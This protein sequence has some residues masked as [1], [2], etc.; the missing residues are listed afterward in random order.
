MRSLLRTLPL[1]CLAIVA[2]LCLS[3]AAATAAAAGAPVVEHTPQLPLCIEWFDAATGH[4]DGIAAGVRT[5]L[6]ASL[7]AFGLLRNF[8]PRFDEPNDGNGGGSG[9]SGNSLSRHD[10]EAIVKSKLGDGA[11]E[12]I[13]N[14]VTKYALDLA[15]AERDRDAAKAALKQAEGKVP[16]GAVVLTGDDAKAYNELKAGHSGEGDFSLKTV[17]NALKAGTEAQTKLARR[18]R[19]DLLSSVDGLNAKAFN[20]I[21]GFKDLEVEA[22]GEGDDRKVYAVV[23]GKKTPLLDH[24]NAHEDADVK[25]LLLS[26]SGSSGQQTTKSTQSSS[27]GTYVQQRTTSTQGGSGDSDD[28]V[29]SFL[30]KQQNAVNPQPAAEA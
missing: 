17:G 15:Q 8:G 26:G 21:D 19:E 12:R 9:G 11:S 13:V 6:A 20:L 28:L 25:G 3:V 7:P 27:S 10:V 30:S 24:I 5:T 2:V 29:G 16:D 4:S 1:F 14:T 18:T 22:E 23:D